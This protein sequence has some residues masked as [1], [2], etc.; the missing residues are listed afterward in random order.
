M[1]QVNSF[2]SSKRNL[3]CNVQQQF[4]DLKEMPP[5][6]A[7]SIL[8]NLNATDLCLASCVWKDL[9]DDDILWKGLCYS[10]WSYTSIYDKLK[11]PSFCRQIFKEKPIYKS[12]YLLLDETTLLFA[13]KPHEGIRLLL[14]NNVLEDTS[15]D[16]AKF[17]NGTSLNSRSVQLLLVEREDILEK[18]V[19][20]QNF[21]SLTICDSMRVIFKKV[22]PPE[23]RGYF[24]Q[25]LIDL[26]AKKY[27]ECN[28]QY[29]FNKE[30]LSVICYSI[31][32]LSVDLYSPHVK[33]KMSKR[34][35]IR[36]NRQVLQ[37]INVEL[38]SDIYDDVYLNGHIVDDCHSLQNA[39][40]RQFPFYRPYGAIFELKP[41]PMKLTC[42]C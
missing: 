18:L 42:S 31:L 2:S 12:L 38:M 37:N 33:T 24:L 13:F 26:I 11:E 23:Q 8:S 15:E 41:L 29:G 16:I 17:I 10:K 3:N 14:M 28:P 1:G 9:G 40:H 35:F 39:K 19:E 36:N 21:F 6:I 27:L 22:K 34:E 25:L 32:L 4:Q 20:M 7:I 5:E 30:Q